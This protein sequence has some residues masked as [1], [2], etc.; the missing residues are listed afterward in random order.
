[1]HNSTPDTYYDQV[2]SSLHQKKAT[3]WLGLQMLLGYGSQIFPQKYT[4]PQYIV[5][6]TRK[7]LVN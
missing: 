6:F 1:M 5:G 4:K 3:K 7:S 2:S